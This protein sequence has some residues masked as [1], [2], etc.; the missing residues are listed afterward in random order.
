MAG[1]FLSTFHNKLDKKGRV[2][3]PASYRTVLASQTVPGVVVFR[4]LSLEAIESFGMDRMEKLS[5]QL[6][7]MDLFSEDQQDWSASI[8][9][10]AQHLAFD[11]EG[12]I[13]IPESFCDHA[14]LSDTV[15]FVGR[16]PTFQL[17]NPEKFRHYQEEA[18]LR[19]RERKLT[20]LG[21]VMRRQAGEGG[22]A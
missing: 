8:F 16:G 14:G 1:L 20:S 5:H 7:Q 22:E 19:L 21:A 3:V 15:A 10:D 13:V 6:D 11:S 17:W 2:S 18:R 9:A 12:R 4:S